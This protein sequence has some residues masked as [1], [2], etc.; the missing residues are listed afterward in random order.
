MN[1][2]LAAAVADLLRRYDAD[3]LIKEINRQRSKKR[4][5]RPPAA[6]RHE[7]LQVFLMVEKHRFL[8]PAGVEKT[9]EDLCA[10][11]LTVR[12][13]TSVSS[14]QRNIRSGQTLRR[15]YNRA[16]RRYDSDPTA[17]AME[18]REMCSAS[19]PSS[20]AP[21]TIWTRKLSNK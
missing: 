1:N 8:H 5:G 15:I 18:M 20:P 4:P 11:G 7:E 2:D 6:M 3:L 17:F 14:V 21:P 9:C 10:T 13:G 19:S 16:K 12:V